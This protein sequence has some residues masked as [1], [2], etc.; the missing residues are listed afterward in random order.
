M[1]GIRSSICKSYFIS[2]DF[3]F[4]IQ[5]YSQ[6]LSQQT[7]RI[8]PYIVTIILPIGIFSFLRYKTLY[9]FQEVCHTLS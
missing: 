8:N 1:E 9:S 4:Y 3:Y 7:D 6:P 5:I 2:I